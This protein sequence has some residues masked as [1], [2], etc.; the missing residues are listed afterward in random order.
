[1]TTTTQT[2]IPATRDVRPRRRRRNGWPD[3]HRLPRPD[4]WE[5]HL[6]AQ[7]TALYLAE[8]EDDQP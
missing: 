7:A 4:G 6:I 3:R 5:L 1:M 8:K 2:R